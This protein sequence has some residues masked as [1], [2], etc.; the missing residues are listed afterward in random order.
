MYPAAVCSNYLGYKYCTTTRTLGGVIYLFFSL[1]VN[2]YTNY[3]LSS[4]S[5]FATCIYQA[6]SLVGW[7]P[8]Y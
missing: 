6:G 1:I 8:Q 2:T 5:I 3:I 7:G 4:S